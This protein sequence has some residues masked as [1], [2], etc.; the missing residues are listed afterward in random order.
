M[1]TT[2]LGP[3]SNTFLWMCQ[4]ARRCFQALL[5]ITSVHKS[6]KATDDLFVRPWKGFF[7]GAGRHRFK[8][9]Y[10][11][12]PL[13]AACDSLNR[14][15]FLCAA[16]KLQHSASSHHCSHGDEMSSACWACYAIEDECVGSS[17]FRALCRHVFVA[18]P[19]TP[20]DHTAVLRLSSIWYRLLNTLRCEFIRFVIS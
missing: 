2:S 3:Y 9:D 17:Y 5:I 1:N 10:Q 20:S 15:I 8:P 4:G 11:L 16:A 7:T 14:S 13:R 18:T 19:F 6:P 12:L